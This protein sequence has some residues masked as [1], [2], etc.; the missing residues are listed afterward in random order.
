[1]VGALYGQVKRSQAHLRFTNQLENPSGFIQALENVNTRTGGDKPLGWSIPRAHRIPPE[2]Q[3][4][5]NESESENVSAG[6][7]R[8]SDER[9][10]PNNESP[11]DE[12][13][14][15]VSQVTKQTPR[16]SRLIPYHCQYGT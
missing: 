5:E 7:G 2:Q 9:W 4:N 3:E 10:T 8:S 15:I 13:P 6:G 1:M 16:E 11:V 12:A 14:V